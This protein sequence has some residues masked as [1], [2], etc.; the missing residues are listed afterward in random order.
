MKRA[1][2]Y[3][4]FII[5]P[6]SI[7]GLIFL[8]GCNSYNFT[9]PQPVD[10]ENI[11]EFPPAFR[12]IWIENNDTTNSNN[13]LGTH[14]SGGPFNQTSSRNLIASGQSNDTDSSWYVIDKS[15]SMLIVHAKEKIAAGAWPKIDPEKT[16]TDAP[17][18]NYFRRIEYDSLLN[19]LDTINNY[20][21]RG[22]RIYEIY[23]ER[24]LE[25]GYP[26]R[27]D[28]DTIVVFKNDTICVDLG[29]NAFLR[30]LNDN[31]YVLNIRNSI[32]GEES[33]WWRLILLEMNDEP[34][35]KLWECNSKTGELPSMF[36]CKT[37]KK[38]IF[39]FDSQ[40]SAS[41][42]LKLVKEGYFTVS[43]T[44]VKK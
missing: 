21:I 29:Q 15:F 18:F 8:A 25:K 20:V 34:V 35:I 4:C 3:R 13:E 19:P 41:D 39:Y 10:K 12:G 38:D 37:I 36:Y 28:G 30:K 14:Y 42:I 1:F 44:L 6:K 23:E 33:S 27:Y 43:A 22:N 16:L 31:Y 2:I 7:I 40:W 11:Y 5:I 26:F 17:F 9:E 32:L 24:F